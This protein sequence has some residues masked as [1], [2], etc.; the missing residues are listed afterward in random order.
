MASAFI[1]AMRIE[2]GSAPKL[3]ERDPGARPKGLAKKD[4]LAQLAELTE[5]LEALHDRLWAEATRAV[6]LVLQ[7]VDASGQGRDDQARPHAA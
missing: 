1:D 3:G 5:R 2:P 4:G 6:L 7:G